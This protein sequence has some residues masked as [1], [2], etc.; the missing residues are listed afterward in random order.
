MLRQV[1]QEFEAANGAISMAD[2][3]RKLNIRESMLSSMLDFWVRQ[4][5]LQESGQGD[6]PPTCGGC[7]IR[8]ACGIKARAYSLAFERP[9]KLKEKK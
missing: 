7:A 3:S 5:V 6:C 2:L 1:L 8:Q 4:G 9:G